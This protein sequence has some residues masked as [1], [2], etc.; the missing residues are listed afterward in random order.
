MSPILV[1]KDGICM[2]T[3]LSG[4]TEMHMNV[5]TSSVWGHR[6][7]TYDMMIMG[8]LPSCTTNREKEVG[9]KGNLTHQSRFKKRRRT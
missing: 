4:E 9:M 1:L 2:C 6:N 7:R 3:L 5:M 8:T